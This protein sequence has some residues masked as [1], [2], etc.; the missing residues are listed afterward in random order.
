MAGEWV[1]PMAM[2]DFVSQ[3]HYLAV[4]MDRADRFGKPDWRPAEGPFTCADLEN[5]SWKKASF[6]VRNYAG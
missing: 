4:R 2:N 6:D 5:Y 1:Q 3:R